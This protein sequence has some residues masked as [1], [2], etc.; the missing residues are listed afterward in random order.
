MTAR[1]FYVHADTA[2]PHQ[3]AC[4]SCA[5]EKPCNYCGM[6]TARRLRCTNGRCENCH[7]TICTPGGATSEGHAF[8]QQGTDWRTR[9]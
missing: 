2:F 3:G 4:G 1:T 9:R 6:S 5:S 7:A 8:G